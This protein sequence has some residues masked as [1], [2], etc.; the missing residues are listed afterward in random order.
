MEKYSVLISLYIKEDPEYLKTAIDSMLSQ[1]VGPDEIVIVKDGPITAELEAVL[2]EFSSKY[3][4]LFN[5]VGYEE[6]KGLGYA[7]NYGMKHVRNEL[8]A[9]MDTD[10]V[11]APDRCEK[12]LE[13]FDKDPAIDIA[14]GDISEFIDNED[15]IVSYRNVPASNDEIKQYLKKRC[16]FNHMTVMYKKTAV[17]KAGGYMDLFWNEDYYL[18]IRMA[19]NG[20]V[21]ANTGNVLVNVRVGSDMYKRRGGKKYFKSEKFLQKYMLKN[22]IIGRFTYTENMAKRFIVQVLL[23]NSIRGWVFRTFARRKG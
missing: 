9:R 23:P 15:N 18:W 7:L 19:Q 8:V 12:Q 21:M 5:I 22:K 4:E 11:A 16:P 20:A 13:L 3:P 2:D 14:G 6:N 17:E 1:T 10:D